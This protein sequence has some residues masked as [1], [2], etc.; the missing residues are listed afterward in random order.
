MK[1]YFSLSMS[2]EEFY[3]YYQGKISAFVV[4]TNEGLKLQFPA[5][6]LRNF[7]TSTGIHGRFCLESENNKFISL[8]KLN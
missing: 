6:H 3:P 8:T 7:L 2:I 4:Y 5:M 1:Y